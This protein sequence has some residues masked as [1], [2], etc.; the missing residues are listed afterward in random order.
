MITI[1]LISIL[2][3][4]CTSVV[5]QDDKGRIWHGRNLDYGMGTLLRNITVIVDFTRNDKVND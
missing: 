3:L 5:A 4:G 2:G 1:A